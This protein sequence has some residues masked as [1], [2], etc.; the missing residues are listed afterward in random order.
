MT[1][2]GRGT[3]PAALSCRNGGHPAMTHGC[4]DGFTRK[5]CCGN[6]LRDAHLLDQ[7][8]RRLY[9]AE[10]LIQHLPVPRPVPQTAQRISEVDV[11]P[12]GVERCL[13]CL[14]RLKRGAVGRG[15]LF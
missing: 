13:I 10:R 6:M 5:F 14:P 15:G 1:R 3:A 8:E 4:K 12:R 11:H 7:A 2:A 9:G